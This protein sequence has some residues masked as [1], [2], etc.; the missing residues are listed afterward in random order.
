MQLKISTYNNQLLSLED[1]QKPVRVSVMQQK[2]H[3]WGVE[4]QEEVVVGAAHLSNVSAA[5]PSPLE[6]IMAE[7]MELPVPA[8][9]RIPLSIPLRKDTEIL[10]IDVRS[11]F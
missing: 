2:Q 8:D 11:A 9:G 10:L 1:R 4:V 5:S 3:S 7:E 6:E